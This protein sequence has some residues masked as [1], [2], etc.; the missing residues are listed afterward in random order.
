[1]G[2]RSTVVIKFPE[3]LSRKQVRACMRLLR[4]ALR[5]D[6]PNIVIDLSQVS[7]IDTW[8]LDM[9]L[10]CMLEVAKRDGSLRLAGASPE[11][12]TVLEL[13]RMDR[14]FNMFPS[15][16]DAVTSANIEQPQFVPQLAEP[17]QQPAA[18]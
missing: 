7:Q 13:T 17:V 1:M 4:P 11:A 16:A 5:L 15:V 3:Q 8:G 12:A 14:V 18:A 9:L 6:Q 2:T 10:H